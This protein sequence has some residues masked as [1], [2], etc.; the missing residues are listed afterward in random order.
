MHQYAM[1]D[2]LSAADNQQGRPEREPSTTTRP[3]PHKK[4]QRKHRK[5]DGYC[6]DLQHRRWVR[7]IK[8]GS[9][10]CCDCSL[11]KPIV[12]FANV[13]GKPYSYCRD[14]QRL[15]KAMSRYKVSRIEAARLYSVEMCE[16]CDSV[17]LKQTH[18]HIHHL[19]SG[20]IGVVCLFCN[21]T[22]RDESTEHLRRLECCVKYIHQRVKI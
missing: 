14:C 20:V 16:C 11:W 22:L 4:K 9:A 19:D 17:F 10:F 18:K 13:R 21:H 6:W 12:A 15:H 8:N 1:R 7:E 2:N 3:A 5:C